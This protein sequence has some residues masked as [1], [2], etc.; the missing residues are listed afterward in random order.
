MRI[1]LSFFG[2]EFFFRMSKKSPEVI[3]TLVQSDFLPVLK[4]GTQANHSNLD[5]NGQYQCQNK[6][7][8]MLRNITSH[9][10]VV[11]TFFSQLNGFYLKNAIFSL[12]KFCKSVKKNVCGLQ[13][14]SVEYSSNSTDF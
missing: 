2:L 13:A 14:A 6:V 9:V 10:V 11:R 8:S 12:Y 7:S 1:R 4:Y 3:L 5:P